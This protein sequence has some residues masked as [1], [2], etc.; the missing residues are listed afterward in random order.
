MRKIIWLEILAVGFTFAVHAEIVPPERR[1]V[2]EPG[3]LGGIPDV[4]IACPQSAPSVMD[5]GAVGDGVVDDYPAF[6]AAI[7]AAAEGGAIFVPEGDYLLRTGLS[8]DKGVILCG[9]GADKSRLLFDCAETA[10]DIV[11]YDRGTL[12]D[13]TDG[14]VKDSTQITVTDASGFVPGEFAEIRQDNDWVVMDPEDYWRHPANV[15]WVPEYCVG[16]MF[17]VVAVNGNTV[18][19]DPPVHFD[20]NPAMNPQLRPMGLVVGVGIQG[21]YL[22]RLNTA[23]RATVVMKN[24]A[25]CWMRDCESENTFRAHVS[26]A[27]SLRCEIR[28]NYMHHAHDYG[29]GGHGYGVTLGEHVTDFLIEDNIFVFLRHAMMV[30]VGASGNVYGYNYSVETQSEGTWT[31]CDISMH[32]HY[33]HMN[34]FEGNVAQEVDVADYWGPC[35]PGNTLLR[36]RVELEGIQ[37]MD[38]SHRQNVVGNELTTDPNVV[39]E[40][41]NV[42]DTMVHGNYQDGSITWDPN[43]PDHDIPDSYY[44]SSKPDFFECAPWPATGADLAP[45][46]EMIPAERR[47]LGIVVECDGGVD[48]GGDDAGVG[49]DDAG[50]GGDDAG[51]GGDDAGVGGDD[52]GV[53]G[54]DAGVSGDDA[55]APDASTGTDEADAVL[56]GSCGCGQRADGGICTGV[57]LI[58]LGFCLY[59]HRRSRRSIK[60]REI[61]NSTRK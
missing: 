29:G 58:L 53:G 42:Q 49:G 19:V 11:T 46:S 43:I 56:T 5:F 21:L 10:I 61:A 2:W 52:A 20:Y 22:T 24:A 44:H 40:E 16:Q 14:A 17:E 25:Y 12:V 48:G 15:D 59:S 57:L 50:A 37:V 4:S 28:R 60:T 3:V 54:D 39:S 38:Y 33:P 23:D 6:D 51:A 41:G 18:T 31:P 36:N 27:S 32:G 30:Q 34:L 7:S 47:H 55:G 1:I 13:V 8:I 35:G 26:G 45:N 9:E